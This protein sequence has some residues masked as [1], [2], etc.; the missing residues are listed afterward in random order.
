MY[1]SDCFKGLHQHH[2]YYITTLDEHI[3][4]LIIER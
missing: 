3:L 2:T 1:I 4:C